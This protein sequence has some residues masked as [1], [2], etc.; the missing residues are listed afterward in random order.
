MDLNIL[1]CNMN[2][3]STNKLFSYLCFCLSLVFLFERK[4]D[5]NVSFDGNQTATRVLIVLRA[6]P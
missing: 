3:R 2:T 6:I 4:L 5:S 1:S